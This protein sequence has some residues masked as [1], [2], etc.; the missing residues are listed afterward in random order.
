MA[1]D[2]SYSWSFLDA[3]SVSPIVVSQVDSVV[4]LTDTSGPLS[5]LHG[6]WTHDVDR[7]RATRANPALAARVRERPPISN[8]QFR[9]TPSPVN[10]RGVVDIPE[11]YGVRL[12]VPGEPDSRAIEVRIFWAGMQLLADTHE[13]IGPGQASAIERAFRRTCGAGFYARSAG[14]DEA[15][16]AESLTDIAELAQLLVKTRDSRA[17]TIPGGVVVDDQRIKAVGLLASGLPSAVTVEIREQ[18]L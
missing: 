1:D 13:R 16:I 14:V 4:I 11:V 3:V 18:Q 15:V 10:S 5:I 2:E 17:A 9:I 8:Y 6:G 7:A 12:P